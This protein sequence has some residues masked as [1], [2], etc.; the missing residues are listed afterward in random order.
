MKLTI[1]GASGCGGYR[2][3]EFLDDDLADKYAREY[4]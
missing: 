1:I 2:G 4:K 3:V